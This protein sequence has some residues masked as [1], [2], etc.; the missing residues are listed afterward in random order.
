[1]GKVPSLGKM[2]SIVDAKADAP[3]PKLAIEQR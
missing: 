3:R 2:S 1:M